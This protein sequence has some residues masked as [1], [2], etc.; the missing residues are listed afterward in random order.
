MDEFESLTPLEHLIFTSFRFHEGCGEIR[1]G[2]ALR[3]GGHGVSGRISTPA[4]PSAE[5]FAGRAAAA[6]YGHDGTRPRSL[7]SR[8]CEQ[9]I[10]AAMAEARL[11]QPI[12]IVPS[13]SHIRPNSK[14]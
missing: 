5:P 7:A 12:E 8:R 9:P 13:R 4:R 11:L 3:L 10:G 2:V 14:G 6:R 1:G